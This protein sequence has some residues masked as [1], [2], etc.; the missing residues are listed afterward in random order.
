MAILEIGEMEVKWY[1]LLSEIK[2]KRN[3]TILVNL[4]TYNYEEDFIGYCSC[5]DYDRL[6]TE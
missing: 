6:Y 3:I 5:C 2:H 1:Y 4:K